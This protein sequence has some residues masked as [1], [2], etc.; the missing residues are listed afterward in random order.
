MVIPPFLVSV[1]R[2]PALAVRWFGHRSVAPPAAPVCWALVGS[3][4]RRSVVLA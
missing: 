3:L 4:L 2:S 1:C